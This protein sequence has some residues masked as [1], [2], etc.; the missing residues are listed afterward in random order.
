MN[1]ENKEIINN[2]LPIRRF[3]YYTVY[4]KNPKN[5]VDHEVGVAS[6]KPR[7]LKFRFKLFNLVGNQFFITPSKEQNGSYQ[8]LSLEE[9][10]SETKG[11]VARWNVI[12]DGRIADG[13]LDFNLYM[14]PN[15]DF[16]LVLASEKSAEAEIAVGEFNEF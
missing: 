11:K 4:L 7:A 5:K 3:D 1:N 14:F 13:K 15:Q 9:T 6:S 8:V 16:Y 2:I 10:F 12:G